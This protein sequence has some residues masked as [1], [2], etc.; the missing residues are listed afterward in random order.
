MPYTM[1]GVSC[2]RHG[3]SICGMTVHWSWTEARKPAIMRRIPQLQRK[4]T[5]V[6][7]PGCERSC[8]PRV[9]SLLDNSSIQTHVF[10]HFT[11]II[12]FHS[13]TIFNISTDLVDDFLSGQLF[14]TWYRI[15]SC[16]PF[17][18]RP[19]WCR[20]MLRVGFDIKHMDRAPRRREHHN[21]FPP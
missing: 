15:W 6:P 12:P 5:E 13:S 1:S 8:S 21:S 9:S 16:S 20:R 18:S 14:A 7:V 3:V 10:L 17:L 2:A 19:L 11:A 4:R